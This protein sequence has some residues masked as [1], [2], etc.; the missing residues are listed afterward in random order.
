M[1]DLL[2]MVR[3]YDKLNPNVQTSHHFTFALPYVNN[4]NPNISKVLLMGFNPGE[5]EHD[6]KKTHGT[7]AEES[8]R[9]NFNDKNKSNSS[10]RWYSNIEFFLPNTDVLITEFIFWSSKTVKQLEERIGQ[11]TPE[12]EVV[13][14]C[15][16]IN[17]KLIDSFKP[18]AVVFT[19]LSHYNVI[20]E[21]FSLNKKSEIISQ[22]GT[23]IATIAT[24]YGKKWIFCRHWTGSFGFSNSDKN[25]L[26]NIIKD[27]I[28]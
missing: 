2:S 24:G 13:N 27:F 5:T 4:L 21:C 26:K 12:N 8:F 9:V 18:D 16:D 22:N 10:N 23:R 15:V 14:F 25:E 6:W 1:V 17:K 19:G 20:S 7:R 3:E 11:I 28:M